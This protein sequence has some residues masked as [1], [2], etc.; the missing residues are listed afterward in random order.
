MR[1][2]SR[3]RPVDDA[4]LLLRVQ[5]ENQDQI[6]GKLLHD[7]RN[8]VHSIRITIELFSR[9]ARKNGDVD[10]LMDRAARYIGPAEAALDDLLKNCQ[11]LGDYLAAPAAPAIAPLNIHSWLGEIALLLRSCRRELHVTCDLSNMDTDLQI[12]ADRPRLSHAFLRWALAG[13]S[14]QVSLAART[15]PDLDIVCI[16]M[17]CDAQECGTRGADPSALP[18]TANEL[19]V[20]IENAGGNLA[21][22]PE[23]KIS[24]RF[25][26][27]GL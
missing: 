2:P 9:L 8:P 1:N 3:D 15:A 23:G 13:E 7:L 20:L 5:Q 12:A 17:G 21:I 24:A 27:A 6:L 18:F 25:R 16:E 22:V 11:R 10:A 4:A 14:S 19:Q 26:K